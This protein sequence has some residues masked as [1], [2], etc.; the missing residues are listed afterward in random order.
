VRAL[1]AWISTLADRSP[2]APL[3]VSLNR[4]APVRLLPQDVA[5]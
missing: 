5:R 3:F 4:H 1:Q 2:A